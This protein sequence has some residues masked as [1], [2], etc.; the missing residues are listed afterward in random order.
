MG[1]CGVTNGI[2][3]KTGLLPD[4]LIWLK[5]GLADVDMEMLVGIPPIVLP[6]L[7]PVPPTMELLPPLLIRP[8]IQALPDSGCT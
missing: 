7:L 4:L 6:A 8:V 2:I 3:N 1:L 5:E